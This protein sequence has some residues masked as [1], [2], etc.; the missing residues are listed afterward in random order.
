MLAA[1]ASLV[2]CEN[3]STS[4]SFTPYTA[5]Y[6]DPS[7]FRGGVSCSADEG[8]MK[9][10]VVT[11]QDV[12]SNDPDDVLIVASSPPTTCSAPAIFSQVTPGNFYVAAIDAYELPP[13]PFNRYDVTNCLVPAGGWGSGARL[14]VRSDG[15]GIPAASAYV[16]PTWSTRC[17][18]LPEASE[19]GAGG[20]TSPFYRYDPLGPSEAVFQTAARMGGCEPLPAPTGP[21]RVVLRANALR[22]ALS[23]GTSPGQIA[24][25]EVRVGDDAPRSVDCGAELPFEGLE[26]NQAFVARVFALESGSSGYRWG[27]RCFARTVAGQTRSASCDPLTERGTLRL[28][29]GSLCKPGATYRATVVGLGLQ[30]QSAVCPADLVFSG[31]PAGV[32]DVLVERRTAEGQ[33]EGGIVCSGSVQP[34]QMSEAICSE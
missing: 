19:T 31:L 10:Y 6:V 3:P 8:A 17:G 2:A 21:A 16:P 11:L 33:V 1:V 34:G 18:R 5:L 12:S 28:V 9:S 13:C 22:G 29:G 14:M 30:P 27:T 15:A 4:S 23:C 7:D 25:F 20:S 24:R 32:V 26:P